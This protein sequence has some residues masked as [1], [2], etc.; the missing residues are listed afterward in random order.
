LLFVFLKSQILVF[1]GDIAAILSADDA[2]GGRKVTV[3]CAY[4]GEAE[5]VE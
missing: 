4:R 1:V 5:I 3:L 2:Y